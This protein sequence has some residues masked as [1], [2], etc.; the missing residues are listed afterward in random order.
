MHTKVLH[1]A[2]VE[3]VMRDKKRAEFWNDSARYQRFSP[4]ACAHV[5]DETL[6]HTVTSGDFSA[7]FDGKHARNNKHHLIVSHKGK[8]WLFC[9]GWSVE[10]LDGDIY[11]TQGKSNPICYKLTMKRNFKEGNCPFKFVEV[12]NCAISQRM[13]EEVDKFI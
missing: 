5:W 11:T 3:E 6:D 9:S 8:D 10:V 1:S 7:R 4:P 2:H 13:K 12:K